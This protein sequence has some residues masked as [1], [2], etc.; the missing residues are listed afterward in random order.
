MQ[1]LPKTPPIPN[2]E[3]CCLASTGTFIHKKIIVPNINI[4][5]FRDKVCIKIRNFSS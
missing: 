5:A 3:P 4:L 2:K 1:D